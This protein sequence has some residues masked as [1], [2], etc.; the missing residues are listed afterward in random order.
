MSWKIMQERIQDFYFYIY[1]YIFFFWGGAQKIMWQH[2][3]H[4]LKAQSPL[5]PG[6]RAHLRAL[7]AL[8]VFN[9]LLCYPSLIFKHSDT[10][11]DLKIQLLIKI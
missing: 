10:K 9:A 5:R 1:I 4:K 7:E 6:S 3:N 8:W 11:W 2:A